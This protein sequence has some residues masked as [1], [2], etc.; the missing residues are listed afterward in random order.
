M[1]CKAQGGVLA[2]DAAG[3]AAIDGTG[4]RGTEQQVLDDAHRA[5]GAGWG[6]EGI[7]SR[8]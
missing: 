6:R 3:P 8:G 7:Y 4:F 5:P 1:G 2:A